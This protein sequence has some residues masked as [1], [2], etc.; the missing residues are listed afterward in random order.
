MHQTWAGTYILDACVYLFPGTNFALIDSDCVPVTLYEIQELWCSCGDLDHVSASVAPDHTPTSP[1]APAHKRARSVD[2]GKATQ[3]PG[4][5][6][7]LPKSRSVENLVS[8]PL[9]APFPGSA[10]NPGEEVDYGESDERSHHHLPKLDRSV[11]PLHRLPN[12]ATL[13]GLAS[14]I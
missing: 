1:I 14:I 3:Q 6:V 11:A 10:D 13:E 9:R 4:P 8:A 7:K 12:Q 5:P 2:T